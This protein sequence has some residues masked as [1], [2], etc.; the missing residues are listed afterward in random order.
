MDIDLPLVWKSY[1]WS[2][3]QVQDG[4]NMH[5]LT[6]AFN[7]LKYSKSPTVI[8][9]NTIKGKGISFMENNNNWHHSV[10]TDENYRK[11]M[12]EL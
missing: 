1:G 2:V 12:L 8:I 7:A 3:I 6:N 10:L 9:A 11:A 5:Q 4:H